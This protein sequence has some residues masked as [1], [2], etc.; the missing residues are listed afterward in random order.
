[1]VTLQGQ[2][3]NVTSDQGHVVTQL[4]RI[5]YESMRMDE[6]NTFNATPGDIGWA[7]HPAWEGERDTRRERVWGL[8]PNPH[9]KDPMVQFA[10]SRPLAGTMAKLYNVNKNTWNKGGLD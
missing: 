7:R 1:M 4:G 10:K 2:G 5:A 6:T 3:Q 9:V 8:P